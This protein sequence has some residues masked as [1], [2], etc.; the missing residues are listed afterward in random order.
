[1]LVLADGGDAATPAHVQFVA[2]AAVPN[3]PIVLEEAALASLPEQEV[4]VRRWP[5]EVLPPQ[6]LRVVDHDAHVCLGA[7]GNVYDELEYDSVRGEGGQY[8]CRLHY[9]HVRSGRLG[10]DVRR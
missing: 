1:M 6:C 7:C 8:F 2:L 10:L 4:L 5:A 3:T 9:G